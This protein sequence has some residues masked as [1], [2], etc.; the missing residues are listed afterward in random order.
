MTDLERAARCA[1]VCY[2]SA[3]IQ[4]DGSDTMF[5]LLQE[6][7][8][9]LWALDEPGRKAHL[10]WRMQVLARLDAALH[11]FCPGEGDCCDPVFWP[12]KTTE[13]M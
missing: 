8:T 4:G 9:T 5:E 13:G 2:M 11:E 10:A 6:T 7:K 1:W 3:R 12:K